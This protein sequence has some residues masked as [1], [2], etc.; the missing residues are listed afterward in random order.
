[1]STRTSIA[2]GSSSPTL[3][4]ACTSWDAAQEDRRPARFTACL[5]ALA[6]RR[7]TSWGRVTPRA[8]QNRV[9]TPIDRAS[10]APVAASARYRAHFSR[11]RGPIRRDRQDR[12]DRSFVKKGRPS[13]VR[14]AFYRRGARCSFSTFSG[15]DCA[16]CNPLARA[17]GYPG[18]ASCGARNTSRTGDRLSVTSG[19]PCHALLRSEEL[20]AGRPPQGTGRFRAIVIRRPGPRSPRPPP[21]L[22]V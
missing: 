8:R 10:D 20:R 7:G 4:R 9:T 22:Q 5:V 2:S 21:L 17:P 6:G 12:L 18:P 14:G 15:G 1:M 19:S 13:P 11:V 16:S 3:R